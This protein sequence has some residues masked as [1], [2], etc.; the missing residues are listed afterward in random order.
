MIVGATD[1]LQDQAQGALGRALEQ[2]EATRQVLVAGVSLPTL[3]A[4]YSTIDSTVGRM[5]LGAARD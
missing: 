2:G 3:A 5:A 1:T 4:R